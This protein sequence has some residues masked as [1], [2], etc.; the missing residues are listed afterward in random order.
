MIVGGD[1]NEEPQ[2]KPIA[3]IMESSF[4]DLYT[5]MKVQERTLSKNH[6]E[7]YPSFTTF[8]YRENQGYIKRC[9]DYMF[10]CENQYFKDNKVVIEEYLDPQ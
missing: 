5:L 7:N 9:I 2:N 3:D 6:I 8:K 4:F 1:F 10:V